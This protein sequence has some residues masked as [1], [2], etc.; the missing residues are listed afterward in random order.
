MDPEHARRMLIEARRKI[1]DAK[2]LAES[3]SSQSDAQ[4]L[5]HIIAFEI[6]LKCAIRLCG[7]KASSN[8]NYPKL[9]LA[10]PIDQVLLP[11]PTCANCGRTRPVADSLR[12]PSI[13]ARGLGVQLRL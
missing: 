1:H 7:E 12:T 6:L 13:P 9:W 4:A 2:I 10:H 11:L 8:H 5:I 3:A